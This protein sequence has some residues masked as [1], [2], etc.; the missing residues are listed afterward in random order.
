MFRLTE[1]SHKR[2][3]R[4]TQRVGCIPKSADWKSFADVQKSW[5]N[6][7]VVGRF[8]VFDTAAAARGD[9]V[10]EFEATTLLEARRV[11]EYNPNY[12]NALEVVK[13]LLFERHLRPGTRTRSFAE[14]MLP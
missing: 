14:F 7:D 5:K 6:S 12:V 2:S 9:A 3:N 8:V 4:Q 1:T 11:L 10:H 13:L